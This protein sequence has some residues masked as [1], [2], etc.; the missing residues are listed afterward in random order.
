MKIAPADFSAE[1]TALSQTYRDAIR[2]PFKFKVMTGTDGRTRFFSAQLSA[3][4]IGELSR[5][6]TATS[7]VYDRT[8]GLAEPYRQQARLLLDEVKDFLGAV[9]P[10]Y[11]DAGIPTS[12]VAE[13]AYDH[14]GRTIDK[15][16]ERIETFARGLRVLVIPDADPANADPANGDPVGE[17][18]L[19]GCSLLDAALYLNDFNETV[20]R[21]TVRRWRN[22]RSPKVPSPIGRDPDHRQRRLYQ[23][24]EMLKFIETA[25]GPQ[26]AKGCSQFLK[27]RLREP[28]NPSTANPLQ[29]QRKPAAPAA[30]KLSKNRARLE[31]RRAQGIH[32]VPAFTRKPAALYW[33]RLLLSSLWITHSRRQTNAGILTRA[34]L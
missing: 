17:P 18:T 28:V 34:A 15:F 27:S 13:V 16:K 8:V 19:E 23:L 33:H 11:A 2:P 1:L 5:L 12:K 25:E 29:T 7:M 21:A 9:E 10:L 3:N 24:P 20:A 26:Q 6:G 14:I 4:P 32:L 22:S 30:K 31:N